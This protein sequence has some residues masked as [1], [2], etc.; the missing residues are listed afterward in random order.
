LIELTNTHSDL[1]KLPVALLLDTSGGN[2]I[3]ESCNEGSHKNIR[4]AELVRDYVHM[5][6]NAGVQP[7]QIGIITPYNGQLELLRELLK[8]GEKQ[9]DEK[10]TTATTNQNSKQIS[11]EGLEI[12][13]V[14][15]FQGGEKECIILSLVRSN[16][17][18][19]VGFLADSRRINVAVTRARRQLTLICDADTCSSN[20]LLGR[21]INHITK[22]GVHLSM[23]DFGMD[24][25]QQFKD[26]IF[27]FLSEIEYDAI[28]DD[29]IENDNDDKNNNHIANKSQ[30]TKKERS[31]KMKKTPKEVK[32]AGGFSGNESP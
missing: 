5:L 3:E 22:V 15:G 27:D 14:D 7:H 13:T 10:V 18:R 12:R 30:N 9:T 21:L 28:Q 29:I 19:E 4:E 11:L 2:F 8:F 31:V 6:I 17:K 26:Y 20:P 1:S 16:D 32:T 23:V 24:P 25:N